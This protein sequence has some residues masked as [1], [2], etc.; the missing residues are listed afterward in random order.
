MSAGA[1]QIRA[2]WANK[3]KDLQKAGSPDANSQ[4]QSP[5]GGGAPSLR[6]H[7][8][9]KSR[10]SNWKQDREIAEVGQIFHELQT[11]HRAHVSLPQKIILEQWY[12]NPRDSSTE[13]GRASGH[14]NI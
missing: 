14:A 7:Q 2:G 11:G 9:R 5:G 6:G 1:V 8:P 3:E 4:G 10:N 13:T 12:P